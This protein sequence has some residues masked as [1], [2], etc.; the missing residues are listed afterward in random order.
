M[1]SLPVGDDRA[2]TYG[3][4]VNTANFD[5]PTAEP[6]KV[7]DYSAAFFATGN[8]AIAKRRLLEVGMH[9]NQFGLQQR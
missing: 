5:D 2:F 1:G 9:A 8:V 7:T 6:F 4:V 3:R